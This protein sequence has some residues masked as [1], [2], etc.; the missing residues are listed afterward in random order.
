SR[1]AVSAG[2]GETSAQA[3]SQAFDNNSGAGNVI[4]GPGVGAGTGGAGVDAGGS[5][6]PDSGG[7]AINPDSDTAN[8]STPKG[9]NVT[10]YQGLV[11]AAILLLG[12]IAI[13]SIIAAAFRN[14]G[15]GAWI[16]EYFAWIMGI[17][18]A[19]V[20]MLGVAIIAQGET[21]IGGIY[22]AS[23]AFVTA[24]ALA[25]GFELLGSAPAVPT[26]AAAAAIASAVGMLGGSMFGGKG[27]S[28][29]MN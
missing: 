13:L 23:G 9:K 25:F 4:S 21:V 28:G 2:K 19:M 22:T 17:L 7:S 1:Q 18:G 14:T 27:S 16:A 3:A 5:V 10:K 26:Y 12:V 6:N 15:I 11:N 29:S 8:V 24:T 20:A